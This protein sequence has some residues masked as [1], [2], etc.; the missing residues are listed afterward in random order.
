MKRASREAGQVVVYR[1]G[2]PSWADLPESGMVQLRLAHDLRNEL[3]A[4]EYRYR[5]LIDGIWSSQSAVSVAEL[6]LA[7]ATAA[8]ERAAALMLAQRKID[9]STIPRAG[10]K[11]ALAEARAARREAK[12]TVKV[13]KAIDKEAAGPLLA[14]AKAARYAAITSTRAE[15]VVAGLFWATAND[16]VQN[17]DTAAKLVALAWKQGRPA[18]RRTRPWKGTGTI[19][20]QV[21][22]QA[23]KPARTPGVLASATSPWR[24]VFRIEPGRSRGEWPGQPS[25]GGTVR[26][27]HATVHLRIEKGA[28]AICLPIVL[29]R[30]LPTDGDVA[31]VQI[32]RRRIA[33]CYRL[34]IAIT[35]RLP[36]PTPALGGVPVSVT[37]GW[38]AA[39]DGAVH[40]ARLG[41]PFGLGPPP[42]WLVK[43]LVAIPASATD[44]DVFAPAIWRLLLARDDSIRG[45]RDDLLDGLREQVITALDEGVEVRLWPDDEDLLRSPVVARWRAPRRFVTLARAWPVEHPMAAMLEAWRLRDRHLWEY[46]SHERDQVIAR[47]RDAYR[48]VAA[49]ICGQASEILLDYPPV[50]ELRQVPDVNEE[51]EYVARAGRR[52]VQFAAPGDLRAA[53]EVAARRRGVKVIDVRVPPE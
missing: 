32:T 45:H 43:H 4:V 39:G 52:Q 15:Y 25:S 34:S 24:N 14:D 22:W 30:P 10:A 35:V 31:G 47:R 28:E 51:D 8:V 18:R 6:A 53:I 19:T 5:E 50:A 29:H 36:E 9:R 37:F 7:D 44:V 40:V 3:V 33:G 12:L 16:V 41:A 26:D 1:Y 20:T 48:S 49:W 21:M 11:Q 17:H 2:C 42:P 38:A 46:E 13:A 23:G 27:D